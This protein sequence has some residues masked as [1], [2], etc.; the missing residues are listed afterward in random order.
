MRKREREDGKFFKEFQE[1]LES[2]GDI[3]LLYRKEN[4][5][6]RNISEQFSVLRRHCS[7][8]NFEII[9][10]IVDKYCPELKD[11]MLSYRDSLLSF[12]KTTTVDVY[13]CAISAHGQIWAGFS[14]MAMKINKLTTECTLYQI[15]MLKE[16][17]IRNA[18][19][20]SYHMD[21]SPLSPS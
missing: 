3:N 12:E 7:Y 20:E 16:S 19:L 8:S 21:I 5:A 13:L 10:K 14:R 18:S 6:V 4:E 11:R 17:I 2:L 1:Y 15:R 9:F